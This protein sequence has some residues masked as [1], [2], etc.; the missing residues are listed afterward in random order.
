MLHHISFSVENP[1]RVA[2]ALTEL[3]VGQFFEFPVHPGAYMVVMDDSY[4]SGLEI[5]PAKTVWSPGDV[6]AEVRPITTDSLHS[7]THVALS[8]TASYE[9]IEAI[10]DREGWLVRQCDRGPFSVI[11]L[12]LENRFMVELLT[13]EMMAN[14]LNFMKPEAYAAFLSQVTATVA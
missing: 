4:G 1:F 13:P 2:K 8:V 10:G 7:P 11:E 14:Y 12:W 9:T 6:E 5:L 3:V